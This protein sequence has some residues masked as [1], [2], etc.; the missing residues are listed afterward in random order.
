MQDFLD[1]CMITG[2]DYSKAYVI[3]AGCVHD[4]RVDNKELFLQNKLLT[5]ILLLSESNIL[6]NKGKAS[7][8][9]LRKVKYVNQLQVS[10]TSIGFFWLQ[11]D[12]L[13]VRSNIT[14]E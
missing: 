8:N 13:H 10:Q 3:T 14:C 7:C 4:I 12:G 2:V 5:L 9:L 11:M 1:Y 6:E